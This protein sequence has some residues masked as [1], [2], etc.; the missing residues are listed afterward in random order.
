MDAF[1]SPWQLDHSAAVTAQI[2]QAGSTRK[3]L[4]KAAQGFENILIRQMLQQ[5]RK[6]SVDPQEGPMAGY[7]ELVDDQM[8]AAMTK[9]GGMGLSKQMAAQMLRQVQAKEL[10]SASEK[11]VTPGIK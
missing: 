8:A 3:Q 1:A 10:M 5:A 6:S 9:A 4:E 11:A 7:L 2:Q